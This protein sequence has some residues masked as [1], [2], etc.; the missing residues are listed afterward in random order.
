MTTELIKNYD[1]DLFMLAKNKQE[2]LSQYYII[3][4]NI[5][6]DL[7]KTVKSNSDDLFIDVYA[8]EFNNMHKSISLLNNILIPLGKRRINTLEIIG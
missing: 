3:D 5:Y 8:V 2:H 4:R 7:M 1:K 6:T